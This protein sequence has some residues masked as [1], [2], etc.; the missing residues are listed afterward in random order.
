MLRGAQ[1]D[2]IR[3]KPLLYIGGLASATNKHRLFSIS[4]AAAQSVD[5][6]A[7]EGQ[8]CKTRRRLEGQELSARIR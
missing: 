2:D 4:R 1:G 3:A 6:R 5:D 8:Q 7:V